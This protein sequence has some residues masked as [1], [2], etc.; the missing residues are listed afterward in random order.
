M[1]RIEG[2]VG[3]GFGGF[4]GVSGRVDRVAGKGTRRK[5]EREWVRDVRQADEPAWVK[6]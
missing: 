5:K 2:G 6:V 3:L 4:R 1:N